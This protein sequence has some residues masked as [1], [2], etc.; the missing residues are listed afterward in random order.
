MET[1]V[2]VCTC[3]EDEAAIC[4]DC[5]SDLIDLYDGKGGGLAWIM[6]MGANNAEHE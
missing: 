5:L 4:A 6:P 2:D 3:R 1:N